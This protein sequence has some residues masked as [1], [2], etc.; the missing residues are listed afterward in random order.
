MPQFIIKEEGKEQVVEIN[1]KEITI[2]RSKKCSIVI[3]DPKSSRLH[4]KIIEKAEGYTL[5]DL[6]SRNGITLNGKPVKEEILT[7]GDAIGIGNSSIYFGQIIEHK[8]QDKKDTEEKPDNRPLS[9]PMTLEIK[10]MT[11]ENDKET[12][13]ILVILDGA[14]SGKDYP[15]TNNITTIGRRRENIIQIND[16]KVSGHHAKIYKEDEH[17]LLINLNSTNGTFID[18]KKIEK[19]VIEHNSVITI[20]DTNILFKDK[21]RSAESAHQLKDKQEDREIKH[22]H[23]VRQ[24][25]IDRILREKKRWHLVTFIYS[26]A[27]IFFILSIL[28]FGFVFFGKILR[29]RSPNSPDESLIT[30]NWS[31]EELRKDKNPINWKI[32]QQEWKID[33]SV[34]KSGR[35]SL[36]FDSSGTSNFA[37]AEYETPIIIRQQMDY[38]V[39][40]WGK[41]EEMLRCGV[42]F[43]WLDEHDKDFRYETYEYLAGGTNTFAQVRWRVTP[44]LKASQLKIS[45]FAISPTGKCW[46]DNIELYEQ[47]TDPE[48]TDNATVSAGDM[49]KAVFDNRAVFNIYRYSTLSLLGAQI[50][51]TTSSGK[52]L[53]SSQQALCEIE[54]AF[55]KTNE[56]Q[57]EF[58]GKIFDSENNIWLPLI[59]NIIAEKEKVAVTSK[60]DTT[61]NPALNMNLTFFCPTRFVEET[62]I[63]ITSDE[64]T[65]IKRDDEFSTENVQEIV[66]GSKD[67]LL[68]VSL[69]N[70]VKLSA[71]K[72][73][74][75]YKVCL[76]HK[77][78]LSEAA[79]ISVIF[80]CF[81]KYESGRI[82]ESFARI[83]SLRKEGK[84]SEAK[85]IALFTRAS[86]VRDMETRDRFDNIISEI[87]KDGESLLSE[88][89]GIINDS[90]ILQH[91]KIIEMLEKKIEK[92]ELAF[93]GEIKVEDLRK[94]LTSVKELSA[95]A[96]NRKIEENAKNLLTTAKNY[97]DTGLLNLA[98]LSYNYVIDRFPN[99]QWAK[100]AQ[101]QV[102]LIKNKKLLE[103]KW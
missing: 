69:R 19:A 8:E 102:E 64:G 50:T 55:T 87:E 35:L 70:P 99:T 89:I 90:N 40:A 59:V 15:L 29:E 14:D 77:P 38:V 100:E 101:Q 78:E 63:M 18:N 10:A 17:Y 11:Q 81:S 66:W 16:E 88:I 25:N 47:P 45:L 79:Q 27:V 12:N 52:E 5:I 28:Y 76:I 21:T 84:L 92:A 30:T 96:K 9:A 3:N 32:R 6:E 72:R 44:P 43:I 98:I 23:D 85:H 80:S 46:F 41:T 57:A 33:N 103:G 34:K 75:F 24:A 7:I 54:K 13:Y 48:L 60:I 95:A 82:E 22:E 73:G 20:G 62:G 36:R 42:K 49:I 68:S 71:V 51:L 26:V 39:R 31:F 2:G 4:C 83:E 37:E 93:P 86:L 67:T 53:T 58:S 74:S 61:L 94:N 97:K 1:D 91:P 56:A 65:E